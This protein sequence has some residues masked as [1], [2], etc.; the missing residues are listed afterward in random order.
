VISTELL[1]TIRRLFYAE[2]WKIGTIASQ[3]G[4]HRDT[5]RGALEVNRL[6]RSRPLRASRLDPYFD[7]IRKT[8]E[9]YPRLRATRLFQMIQDRGYSG[10]VVQ[11]R[12]LVARLRPIPHEAF[13][14][15]TTFAG[16][17]AQ[18]DWADFG[19]VL[20]GRA[21]RRLSCWVLR[22]SF[23]RMLYLEFYF[24]QSLENFLRGHVRA[25]HALGGV[26]RVILYDNLKSA[27]LERRADLVH[28]HPRL[29][30]LCAHYHFRPQPCRPRRPNEKG[31]VERA[32][33]DIRH[34]F[35]AARPFTTLADFNQKALAW[36]DNIV[37]RRPWPGDSS[38]T[39]AQ[40]FEQEKPRLL[41]LSAHPFDCDLLTPVCSR[42]TIYIRFDRNDYSIPPEAVGR[43][44]SLVASD[45]TVR[46]LDGASLIAQHRRSYDRDEC[47]ETPAHKDALLELKRKALGSTPSSRLLSAAPESR[48]FIDRAF[49][50]GESAA[51]LTAQLL[52][53]LDD[54]GESDL[55]AAIQQALERNTPRAS[56]VAY[57][58]KKRH[59][60][61]QRPPALPVHLHHRPELG[62]L[63][64]KPH[65][66]ETYDELSDDDTSD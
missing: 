36:R 61:R 57:L 55:R 37:L 26:P 43:P 24:D 17:Q 29:L 15:L 21:Q 34:S 41:P 46:I 49:E 48:E 12:R 53:L 22:L 10:S 60:Q 25:F 14:R 23:S 3:L 1:A 2:H 64:V 42:K 9:D 56:S 27:V 38:R 31:G 28:F 62:D 59:T 39:V 6:N 5:V 30:E 11:L 47:I 19:R 65:S 32:I 7:F 45:T 52:R 18:V 50:K 20:V 58:L 8:L 40:A 16:E 35:F 44:L 33:Q 51:T 63:H 54:Y 13:L 4:L 66:P